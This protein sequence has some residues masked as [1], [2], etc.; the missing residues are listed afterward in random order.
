MHLK[1]RPASLSNAPRQIKVDEVSAPQSCVY[2][3]SFKRLF[4][5]GPQSTV[6]EVASRGPGFASGA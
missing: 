3:A 4:S 5:T 1:S 2:L 6:P